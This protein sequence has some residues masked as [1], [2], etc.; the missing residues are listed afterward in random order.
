MGSK[1]PLL[2]K[3]LRMFEGSKKKI[4]WRER[5]GGNDSPIE[6]TLRSNNSKH[7]LSNTYCAVGGHSRHSTT[8]NPSEA[9]T[10]Q[11]RKPGQNAEKS[12]S[13]RARKGSGASS[14]HLLTPEAIPG[15]P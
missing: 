2:L 4:H 3:V 12:L 13:L 8:T 11:R 14:L 6:E 10:L 9:G 15:S 7:Y 5:E 1:E